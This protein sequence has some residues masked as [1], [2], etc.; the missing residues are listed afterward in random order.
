MADEEDCA[1]ESAQDCLQLLTSDKIEMV[2]RFVQHKKIG[3]ACGKTCER[4]TRP[5]P[6][7]QHP[8][9]REYVLAAE[10]KAREM[11]TSFGVT[12]SARH[13]HRVEHSVVA[14]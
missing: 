2:R 4:E 3:L 13:L 14:A 10:E 9:A 1:L 12:H 7:R 6:T 8:H 11:I 5:L